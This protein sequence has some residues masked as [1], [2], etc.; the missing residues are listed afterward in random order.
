MDYI[1]II[2]LVAAVVFFIGEAMTDGFCLLWFSV[3]SLV[4][5]FLSLITDSLIIQGGVFFAVAIILLVSTK[6]LTAK[7]MNNRPTVKSNVD[8]LIGKK[9]KIIEKLDPIEGAGK[10]KINGEVW[11]AIPENDAEIFE[12]GEQVIVKKVDGVKL[13]IAKR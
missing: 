9:A 8:A 7:F 4:A 13:I 3:A 12:L 5:L 11:K 10:V 6:N 2:W 1:W